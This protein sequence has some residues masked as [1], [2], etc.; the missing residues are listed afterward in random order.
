MEFDSE[1]IYGDNDKYIK[2]RKLMRIEYIQTFNI[3]W[4]LKKMPHIIAYH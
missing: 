3:K 4:C 2:T 1:A